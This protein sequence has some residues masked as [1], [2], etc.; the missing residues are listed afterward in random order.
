M[1][2]R[3]S[4]TDPLVEARPVDLPPGAEAVKHEQLCAELRFRSTPG[5][6]SRSVSRGVRAREQESLKASGNVPTIERCI[7][8]TE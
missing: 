1:G 6:Y 7:E 2:R 8:M 3:T 5:Y 4:V